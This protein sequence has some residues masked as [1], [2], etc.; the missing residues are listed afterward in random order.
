MIARGAVVLVVALAAWATTAGG[1]PAGAQSV[2]AARTPIEHFVVLMQQNHSFDNYFGTYPGADGIPADTCIPSNP[3]SADSPCLRPTHMSTTPSVDLPHDATAFVT[4]YRDGQMD[5]FVQAAVRAGLDPDAAM[6]F[7]DDRHIPYYWNLADNFVLFDRFFQSSRGGS[8]PN[9]LFWMAGTAAGHEQVPTGGVQPNVPTIFDRLSQAGVSWRVYVEDYD[10][11]VT[12]R[13]LS[14]APENRR[15]QVAW[16]PLLAINRFLDDPALNGRIVD[17]SEYF[18]DLDRGTLPSVAYI[19][20]ASSS[21]HP[22]G[23]VA[24]GQ[25]LVRNL[26]TTLMRSRYWESSAFAWT[27]DSAGGWYDH[28]APPQVD[29]D[30]YGFR[31]PALLVSAYARQGV[32]DHTELD[33]TSFLR[34][35]EENWDLQPLATRDASANSIRAAFDFTVPPRPPVFLTDSRVPVAPRASL[36]P[37][38]TLYGLA[39]FG[40]CLL[41]LA[42]WRRGASA[43]PASA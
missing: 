39:A 28:V 12:Y 3:G 22:P 30:G 24:A 29:R 43:E 27:Y 2:R 41:A 42:A 4:Q 19:V 1:A 20:P 40:A 25:S 18:A 9:H 38:A 37:V 13:T 15:A 5:G 33:F 7:Y 8:F 34:F 14:R 36:L 26:V 23:S 10:P 17:L 21:E 32:V 31:V 35:I 16:V 11:A 6:G